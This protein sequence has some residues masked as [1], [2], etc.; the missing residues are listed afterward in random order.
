MEYDA[1]FGGA[2]MDTEVE[3]LDLMWRRYYNIDSPL[4]YFLTA[5]IGWSEG[6]IDDSGFDMNL[7]TVSDTE[8]LSGVNY[9]L[10]GGI[11]LYTTP[12]VALY[13]QFLWRFGRYAEVRGPFGK[14]LTKQ[15]IDSDAWELGGGA[16][17][18]LLR[19]RKSK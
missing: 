12:W 6:T 11:T 8:L 9:N 13:G 7:M 15:N 2:N 10:G 19:P 17:F 4:Q 5:G 1:S 16:N 14:S 3:F 18:R